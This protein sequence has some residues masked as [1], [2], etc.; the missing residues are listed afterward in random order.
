MKYVRREALQ[1]RR[2]KSGFTQDSLG[3]QL[4]VNARTIRSWEAGENEPLPELRQPLA[5]ALRVTLDDLDRLLAGLPASTT[6]DNVIGPH[7]RDRTDET[8]SP[9]RHAMPDTGA[10]SDKEAAWMALNRRGFVNAIATITL[11]MDVVPELDRL[12][13]LLPGTATPRLPRRLGVADI[14][15]IEQLTRGFRDHDYRYGGG[16]ARSAALAQLE[17]VLKLHDLDCSPAVRTSLR[18]ATADLAQ[19][20]GWMAYD[21]E[22]HD[23]A[24]RLWTI[25]LKL[26]HDVDDPR[27]ADL[28]VHLQL[29]MA[30]QA[31]HRD[32]P[33]EALN[34][35][36]L[37]HATAAGHDHPVSRSTDGYIASNLAWCHASLG[38]VDACRRA[39]DLAERTYLDLDTTVIPPHVVPAE[40]DAQRGHALHL[41]AAT[42]AAFAVEAVD[43]LSAAVDG[44]GPDYARSAAV[45][46][47]GLATSQFRVGDIDA[48]VA[49]GHRAITEISA[50]SSRRAHLRL[51][52]M[53]AVAAP[54]AHRSDVA[55]L[56]Q[57]VKALS[58]NGA[59]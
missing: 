54:H 47:P 55:E 38:N 8:M 12:E 16:L 10:K 1:R 42:D 11:G 39:L 5:D 41:L 23:D 7:R 57:R 31:L 53:A 19:T 43:R 48:A 45:N 6:S 25:A 4:G 13:H 51:H 49:T 33:R 35:A 29:D 3:A 2:R 52:S 30:H 18:L 50:L 58:P 26:V 56:R 9:D 59:A 22:L 21:V 20:A 34:L 27:G 28:T 46:L 36:R 40:L 15:G 44:Y 14:E 32:R 37:A 24:L 17:H